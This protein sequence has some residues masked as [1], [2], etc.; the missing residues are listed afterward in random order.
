M[1]LFTLSVLSSQKCRPG[2]LGSRSDVGSLP[3]LVQQ[4]LQGVVNPATLT[5]F[6]IECNKK[7]G[8]GQIFPCIVSFANNFV[9]VVPLPHCRCHM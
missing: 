6:A 1:F 8:L 9:F 5:A 7:N 3:A 2:G 4:Y